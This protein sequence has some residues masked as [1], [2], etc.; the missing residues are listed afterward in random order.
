MS[1]RVRDFVQHPTTQMVGLYIASQ[2]VAPAALGYVS[3]ELT[4]RNHKQAAALVENW[5]IPIVKI[6]AY[7]YGV[8][9]GQQRLDDRVRKL[10]LKQT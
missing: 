9:M 6:G 1:H 7:G 10:R 8:H 2:H 5:G 3:K 4:H